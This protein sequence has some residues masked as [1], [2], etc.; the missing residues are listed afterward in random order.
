M[1][2]LGLGG[3]GAVIEDIKDKTKVI[4][5]FKR[6]KSSV[7]N[8]N[9]EQEYKA[10]KRIRKKFNEF[11]AVHPNYESK[12]LVPFIG[13]FYPDNIEHEGTIYECSYRME[14][15]VSSRS[16]KLMEHVIL[17]SDYSNFCSKI[18][19][20][21][22]DYES[23]SILTNLTQQQILEQK[24]RGAYLC[25]K[26]LKA[27]NYNVKEIAKSIGILHQL[28]FE[29]GYK[30]NDVEFVLDKRGR[31]CIVDFGM[32][33]TDDYDRDYNDLYRPNNLD[34]ESESLSRTRS[35]SQS[36][37]SVSSSSR[38]RSKSARS[39]ANASPVS[40][41]LALSSYKSASPKSALSSKNS[42]S[43]SGSPNSE[44]TL[45][46]NDQILNEAFIKGRRL[47]VNTFK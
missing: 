14:K 15:I 16:D 13:R 37:D 9:P 18:Q 44:F 42:A 24:P 19:F 29:A 27:R 22:N 20:A 5:L 47:V 1:A 30:P 46:K 21:N 38:S 36:K 12:I 28:V 33:Y 26:E 3:F 32:V 34:D 25:S 41:S 40:P 31:I 39:S 43:P 4:K 23:V 17:N 10:H 45:A 11:I 6:T 8:S 7:V 35:K 2:T